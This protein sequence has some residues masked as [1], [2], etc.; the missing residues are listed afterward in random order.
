MPHGCMTDVR[1]TASQRSLTCCAVV[2]TA[3]VVANLPEM[4][5]PAGPPGGVSHGRPRGDLGTPLGR[6]K[7]II[8]GV[9]DGSGHPIPDRIQG[10]R[11]LTI[12]S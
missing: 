12:D 11:A 4:I 10:Y 6:T 9:R 5:M 8:H 1:W 7:I 2:K 3:A